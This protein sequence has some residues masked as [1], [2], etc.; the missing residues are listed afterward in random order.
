MSSISGSVRTLG[1]IQKMET[2]PPTWSIVPSMRCSA[3]AFINRNST[4]SIDSF[5]LSPMAA[6]DTLFFSAGKELT[7]AIRHSTV[8]F[9][10]SFR[11]W[12]TRAG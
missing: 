3:S 12:A 6:K 2:V 5:V 10:R 1:A 8:I 7:Y 4:A 9:S 11:S